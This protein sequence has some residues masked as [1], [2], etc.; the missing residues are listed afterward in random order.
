[1]NRDPTQLPV[2]WAEI[3]ALQRVEGSAQNAALTDVRFLR[4]I[5]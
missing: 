2:K 1:M 4:S 5:E 3:R